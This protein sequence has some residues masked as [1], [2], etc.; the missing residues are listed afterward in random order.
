[1]AQESVEVHYIYSPKFVLIKEL[2][3]GGWTIST[4]FLL[5]VV[6]WFVIREMIQNP[7]W[8]NEPGVQM[9]VAFVV[10]MTGHFMISS[11]EWWEY[12][13]INHGISHELKFYVPIFIVSMA[14]ILLGK[15]MCLLVLSPPGTRRLTL[16][17][18]MLGL[19][20]IVPALVY[21]VL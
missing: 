20:I 9:G 15:S 18:S 14:V 12:A 7:R 1:M 19:S 21:W 13:L 8:Y 2:G 5:C 11:L 17:W 16:V 3:N 4:G 10:L 6:L